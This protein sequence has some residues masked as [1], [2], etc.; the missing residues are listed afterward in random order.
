MKTNIHIVFTVAFLIC[1]LASSAS[2]ANEYLFAKSGLE[3]IARGL[4]ALGIGIGLAGLFIGLGLAK[5]K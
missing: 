3:A 5:K 2:A 1:C 4:Y